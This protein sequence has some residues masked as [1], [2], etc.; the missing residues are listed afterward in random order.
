MKAT[1]VT[2]GTVLTH[3]LAAVGLLTLVS[4][5]VA[6]ANRASIMNSR[7]AQTVSAATFFKTQAEREAQYKLYDGKVSEL[8]KQIKELKDSKEKQNTE[9]SPSFDAVKVD[10]EIAIKQSELDAVKAK[11]DI[12]AKLLPYDKNGDVVLSETKK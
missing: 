6:Y 4:G 3:V 9:P 2:V 12:I 11:R 8:E 1:K 5:A 10:N 7:K